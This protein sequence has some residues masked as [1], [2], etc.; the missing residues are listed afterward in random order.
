[1]PRATASPRPPGRPRS[2]VNDL[3]FAAT[4]TTLDELGYAR[5][6]VDA[7]GER[8]RRSVGPHGPQAL[9]RTTRGGVTAP[10]EKAG[11]PT[12]GP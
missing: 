9:R 6:T 7:P 3:V 8:R 1:M 10:P 5:A 2:G 4:L 11:R 12:A